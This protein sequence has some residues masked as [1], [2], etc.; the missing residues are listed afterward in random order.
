MSMKTDSAA[1]DPVTLTVVHNRLVGIC[2]EMGTTM[3]RTAYSPIFSES[4]DFSCVLFNADGDMLAQT[5]FCPAQVG[6]IRFVVKWLIAEIGAENLKPGDVVVHNDPYRGG[7]HMPEHVVI[8]PVYYDDELFGYVA[9]IAHLVE[10]GG[11]A[12]GGFAATA[13]EIYQEGLRV[14]P[15]WLIREGEY[16]HD[17][18][19]MI[20][21]NHRA[22]RISWGDLHAMV[23]SLTVAERRVH[24][25]LDAY[26]VEQI[27]TISQQLLDH[28]ERWMRE[29]ILAIPDGVYHFEDCMEDA[30]EEPERDWI[31][32]KLVIEDGDILADF[33]A[34]DPQAEHV[35]NATYG[36]TASGVYN[37]VFHLADNE[38]PHNDGAYR[39]ITV[40]AKPGMITNVVHPGACVGGNTETHPRIWGITMGA[41]AQAAPERVSADTGSTACNFLFG[42]VNP[43]SGLYYVHYHFDGVGWGGRHDADGN[44]HQVIPNGNTQTTPVEIFETRY[45]FL[46]RHYRLRT[47]SGGP[48]RHRGGLGSDRILEVRAPEITMSALFDRMVMKP[49]GIFG[50]EGGDNSELLIRLAGSDEFVTFREAYGTPSNSRVSNI[51]LKRGDRVLLRSSGGGGY[52][53]PEERPVEAVLADVREDFV[54]IEGARDDYGVAI[55]ATGKDLA[56]DHGA[57]ARLRSRPLAGRAIT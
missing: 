8:K 14:P 56:V 50:G 26:G 41:L 1:V 12:V 47:D 9:N 21:A 36:V 46:E 42:G 48:G 55:V 45:P 25:L 44:S 40:I 13:T 29:E 28:A 30:R 19:K 15:V 7:V 43:D 57:T 27:K 20:M 37:A 54:S 16:N 5:E 23:A 35:L 4:R 33:S 39:P 49:W 53:K 3:I 24:E 34:S 11:Q 6:A 38:I 51:K 10:I 52:G 18:W 2:R 17:V 32:L 31:R 22:P